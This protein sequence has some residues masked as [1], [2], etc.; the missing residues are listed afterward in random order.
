MPL[1][2]VDHAT[3]P[4]SEMKIKRMFFFA[5]L[6]ISCSVPAFSFLPPFFQA[7]VFLCFSIMAI[8]IC[9]YLFFD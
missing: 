4:G 6:A 3:E 9:F 7:L 5:H 1:L 8:F 2:Q